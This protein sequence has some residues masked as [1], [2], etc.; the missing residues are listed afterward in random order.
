M[1][2]EFYD[3]WTKAKQGRNEF[4]PMFFSWGMFKEYRL[5]GKKPED[6]FAE[7]EWIVDEPA[8]RD[9]GYDDEQLAWRRYKI[10]NDCEGDVDAFKQ[11]YPSSDIEAFLTSGRPVFLASVVNKRLAEVNRLV[12]GVFD[13]KTNSWQLKS[14]RETPLPLLII[15][16]LGSVLVS[17]TVILPMAWGVSERWAVTIGLVGGFFMQRFINFYFLRWPRVRVWQ[18]T[19]LE[20]KRARACVIETPDL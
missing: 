7:A 2:G 18:R 10:A 4:K 11:E 12:D 19:S 13:P 17:T 5:V 8:L 20:S 9:A 15:S 1:G 16:A 6:Y 3:F 14:W